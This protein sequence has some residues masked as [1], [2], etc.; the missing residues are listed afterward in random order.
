MGDRTPIQKS[1][2]V[3][4]GLSKYDGHLFP[5]SLEEAFEEAMRAAREQGGYD[6]NTV[7]DIK[8]RVSPRQ[9]N[10]NVRTYS[11]VATKSSSALDDL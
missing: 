6:E 8:I 3:F 10:Q 2:D 7:F 1:A 9:D 5:A 4:V 11:V